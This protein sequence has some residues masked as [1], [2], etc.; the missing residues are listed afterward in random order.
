M[1]PL[2]HLSVT[3]KFMKLHII[4]IG[5]PKLGYAKEGWDEY[6]NR[7]QHYHHIRLTQLDD[8]YANNSAK[9]LAT[10][11]NS[12][13]VGLIIKGTQLTSEE[14]SGFLDRRALESR[15]V[16]FL[17]GGPDGLPRDVQAAMDFQWSFSKLTLPHDLAMVTL[18]ESLYRASTI[19]AGTPY[20]H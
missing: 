17:V 6:W 16:S 18:L 2:L 1:Q 19:N 5:K 15:E 10:A 12:Y 9:L 3:I 8:K 11:G 7:L 14:L 4:T 13:K 20:H